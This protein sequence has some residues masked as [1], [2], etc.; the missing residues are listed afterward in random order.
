LDKH[1]KHYID[2]EGTGGL[3]PLTPG[4]K[5]LMLQ[6]GNKE[7]VFV[8]QPEL[9]PEFK[10]YLEDV[11]TLHI[12]QNAVHDWKFIYQHYNVHINNIYDT[13]LAEQ[14]L[15]SGRAGMAV[16]LAAISRRRKPHRI[17]T[18][19]VRNEFIEFQGKFTKEMVYYAV[20]DIVLLPDIV[21]A[22]LEDLTRLNMNLVA[23]DEFNLVPVTGSMELGGVPFSEKTL[24]LALLY[25]E[26]RQK[27]L[28]EQI[29]R[30]YDQRIV[31]KGTEMGFLIPDM[32]F[33][34][35]VNSQSQKLKA[36]RELGLNIDDVKRDTLESLDD[37]IAAL[38]GEY[39]E[40]LKI[41]S[42]YGE[43][44][45]HRINPVTHRL[46]VEFNQLGHGDIEAKAGKA[47]T[48]A[49][50]RYSSDFQQLPKAMNRYD[51]ITDSELQQVQALYADRIATLLK[52]AE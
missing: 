27:D 7:M 25:W 36:L 1:N 18:K 47:T 26:R 40:A 34:F 51:L 28:E 24:R 38:L 17:I 31:A 29:L 42:T 37:P 39:S 49:T 19:A 50:G 35:D 41:N 21:K 9:I 4:A 46:Q 32:R 6:I 45:I 8:I 16:N 23:Q 48:I 12:L 10:E 43:N 5:V 14:L 15:T 22:Q 13:M 2:T 3:N 44:M 30:A 52:E 20:R 33:E 11:N